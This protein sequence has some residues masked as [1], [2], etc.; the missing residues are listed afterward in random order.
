ME[1]LGEAGVDTSEVA[2]ITGGDRALGPHSREAHR[3]LSVGEW[4]A[5]K[6]RR[7]SVD[8]QILSG[9]FLGT[10][11]EMEALA[12]FLRQ[13]PGVTNMILVS[14]PFHLR[15]SVL[16]MRRHAG[17][18]LNIRVAAP[19]AIWRD[20]APWVVAAEVAKIARDGA[21]LANAPWVS[22]KGW[23]EERSP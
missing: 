22:R 7:R 12:A 2:V 19:P 6:L 5:K 21:G 15:R 9:D 13:T 14:S 10:S 17:G 3:R 11:A 1:G 20:Y 16:G 18:T 23:V 4:A 8:A